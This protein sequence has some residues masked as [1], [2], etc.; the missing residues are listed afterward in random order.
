MR[1]CGWVLSQYGQ[2]Y[3]E[4]RQRLPEYMYTVRMHWVEGGRAPS[5]PK[6]NKTCDSFSFRHPD[7]V[8]CEE[9]H[10]CWLGPHAMIFFNRNP[11]KIA[12][13]LD[14][15][16]QLQE[17]FRCSVVTGVM[18]DKVHSSP[19]LMHSLPWHSP[20]FY[21]AFKSVQFIHERIW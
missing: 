12:Y 9:L 14:C 20:C 2:C 18:T 11:G 7:L 13:N 15:K 8:T 16:W 3:Y 10:F 4:K 21:T 6:R 19:S 17:H 5:K 1:A